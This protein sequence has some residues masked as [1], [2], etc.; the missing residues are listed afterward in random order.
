L[1]LI[2]IVADNDKAISKLKFQISDE[3]PELPRISAKPF[4]ISDFS[5]DIV[6]PQNP[7]TRTIDL[8]RG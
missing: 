2:L 4:Q 3:K 7:S 8:R 6:K 5:V 1:R